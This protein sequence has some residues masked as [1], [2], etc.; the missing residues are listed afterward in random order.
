M[1]CDSQNVHVVRAFSP[2]FQREERW[3]SESSNSVTSQNREHS[4][5]GVGLYPLPQR[6]RVPLVLCK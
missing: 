5:S 2:V 1:S 3:L 4:G 6:H